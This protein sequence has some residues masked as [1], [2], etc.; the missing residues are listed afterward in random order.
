MNI[1][2]ENKPPFFPNHVVSFPRENRYG[3]STV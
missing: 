1:S 3:Q 2:G